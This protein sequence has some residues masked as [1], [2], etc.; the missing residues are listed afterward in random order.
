MSTAKRERSSFA[1]KV[2]GALLIV[3]VVRVL[4]SCGGGAGSVDA[5]I[6]SF[7][8]HQVACPGL[9]GKPTDV[10]S[11]ITDWDETRDKAVRLGCLDVFQRFVDC[12]NAN[13]CAQEGCTDKNADIYDDP[14]NLL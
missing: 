12:A 3:V 6:E 5:S 7:C 2:T 13:L 11:C 9:E 10:G 14:C 8:E 1:M 4:G